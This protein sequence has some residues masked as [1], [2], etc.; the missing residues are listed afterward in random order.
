MVSLDIT[1]EG[2]F[3]SDSN[4]KGRVRRKTRL[5]SGEGSIA[6]G[7]PVVEP[8]NITRFKTRPS[9]LNDHASVLT[10]NLSGSNGGRGNFVVVGGCS[11]QR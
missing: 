3:R 9:T 6:E 5:K 11:M 7:T 8:F 1:L 2:P 10:V 4:D